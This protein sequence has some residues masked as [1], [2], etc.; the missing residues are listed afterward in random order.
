MDRRCALATVASALGAVAGCTSG[1]NS[2][3]AEYHEQKGESPDESSQEQIYPVPGKA[4]IRAV[5]RLEY[6]TASEDGRIEITFEDVVFP[7]P[8]TIELYRQVPRQDT[9]RDVI[10]NTLQFHPDSY[11][12]KVAEKETDGTLAGETD[13][14]RYEPTDEP[15][16]IAFCDPDPEIGLGFQYRVDIVEHTL[17]DQPR[18]TLGTTKQLLVPPWAENG[19]FISAR[20]GITFDDLQVETNYNSEEDVLRGQVIMA[21]NR[22]Y[23]VEQSGNSRSFRYGSRYRLGDHECLYA[24]EY[25][26]DGE[27]VRQYREDNVEGYHGGINDPDTQYGNGKRLFKNARNNGFADQIATHLD[28]F[29]TAFDVTEPGQRLRLV[30]DF[31]QIMEYVHDR[32]A[33][34]TRPFVQHPAS[35][36]ALAEGDCED[37]TLAACSLL[38]TDEFD[39]RPRYADVRA[40]NKSTAHA[41]I[42]IEQDSVPNLVSEHPSDNLHTFTDDDGTEYVYCDATEPSAIGYLPSQWR[43]TQ[44]L[45]EP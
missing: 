1:R 43:P 39:F 40:P 29:A 22:G 38:T 16:G 11:G 17:D 36:F 26:F 37:F 8:V 7:R 12:E 34:N 32:D 25:E 21:T 30:L 45:A 20:G 4:E 35:V 3:D 33:P 10:S 44:I 9:F 24:F 6:G 19:E 28:D 27:Q 18:R 5:E 2:S 15:V 13:P 14:P 23:W 41:G 31:V 42:L